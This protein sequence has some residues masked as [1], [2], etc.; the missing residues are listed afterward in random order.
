MYMN[1][2]TLI[3]NIFFVLTL[4]NTYSSSLRI[5]MIVNVF[6]CISQRFIYEQIM[7]FKRLGINVAVHAFKQ[8]SNN[9]RLLVGNATI[10][11]TYGKIIPN[12]T[13]YNVLAVQF[14]NLAQKVIKQAQKNKATG[15]IVVSFRG[16]DLSK[17]L[18]EHPDYY[19]QLF[20]KIDLCLPVCSFFKDRLISMGCPEEKI[21]IHYSGIDVSKFSI[22]NN[23]GKKVFKLVTI[24]RLV[25]KKG[26]EYVIKALAMVKKKTQLFHYF[27]VGD[28]PVANGEKERLLALARSLQVQNYITFTGWQ[29]HDAILD[30]LSIANLVLVPSII[31]DEGDE[32]GIPNVLKEAMASG[33]PSIT[34]DRIGLEMIEDSISGFVVPQKNELSIAQK[35]LF[36]IDNQKSLFIIGNRAR[37]AVIK[38]FDINQLTK[39]LIGCF[40]DLLDPEN[41][42]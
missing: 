17:F 19:T 10:P 3:H 31:S 36:C 1:N 16:H 35:I 26:I 33:I 29:S 30:Y 7:A 28:E 38:K 4:F 11:V 6:P 27:I 9:D 5:L 18:K 20:D 22:K 34:T 24:A 42:H 25:Q 13:S 12:I 23:V 37:Q 32:E 39:K 40:Y 14:G 8:P 41:T 15:K 21:Y 2:Y